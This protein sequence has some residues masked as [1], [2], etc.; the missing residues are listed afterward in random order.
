MPLRWCQ[1]LGIYFQRL[2]RRG[3]TA[4][5]LFQPGSL[6]LSTSSMLGFELGKVLSVLPVRFCLLIRREQ[7]IV[8]LLCSI[9]LSLIKFLARWIQLLPSVSHELRDLR[10]G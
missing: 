6:L 2:A 9:C 7:D 4:R 1:Q 3:A 5:R 8:L 10:E